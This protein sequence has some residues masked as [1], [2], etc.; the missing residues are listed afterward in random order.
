MNVV[1]FAIYH[2]LCH[3]KSF[4]VT[5]TTVSH[6]QNGSLPPATISPFFH[7]GGYET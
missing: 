6:G 1:Y 3:R 5:M 7:K 2:Y 4:S